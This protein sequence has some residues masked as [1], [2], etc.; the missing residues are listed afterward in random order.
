MQAAEKLK[1]H[2]ARDHGVPLVPPRPPPRP[3]L[4]GVAAKRLHG[5]AAA[6]AVPS[7]VAAA[8]AEAAAALSS[9]SI[10]GDAAWESEAA[11]D[12]AAERA[13]SGGE[14]SS[15]SCDPSPAAAQ[16]PDGG[17]EIHPF[18]ARAAA[19]ALRRFGAS[20]PEGRRLE[21]EAQV[22]AFL[23]R[24]GEEGLRDGAR[25]CLAVKGV[26]GPEGGWET[27]ALVV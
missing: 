21:L 2:I 24:E 3:T 5:G 27:G 16:L 7:D 19:V 6:P 15:S 12:A 18:H 17:G 22:L 4:S 20:I 10:G 8:A 1:R 25:G 11:A 9:S 14:A 13:A 26:A 23:G